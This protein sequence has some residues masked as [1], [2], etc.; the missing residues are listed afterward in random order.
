MSWRGIESSS[1]W[2]DHQ[3]RV[4]KPPMAIEYPE[5]KEWRQTQIDAGATVL[6]QEEWRKIHG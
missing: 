6:T 4:L 5:M 2:W 3:A 1:E